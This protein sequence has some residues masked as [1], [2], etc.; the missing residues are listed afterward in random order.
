MTQFTQCQPSM[1]PTGVAC[2]DISLYIM[3]IAFMEE[4][5]NETGLDEPR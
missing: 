1:Y 3:Y 2:L 4:H 5:I